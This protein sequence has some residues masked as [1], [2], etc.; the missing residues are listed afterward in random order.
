MKS[1]LPLF[2]ILSGLL[3]SAPPVILGDFISRSGNILFDANK[4]GNSE[5]TLNSIGLGVGASPSSNLH[6]S[7]NAY[8]SGRLGIGS[9]SPQSTLEIGGSLGFGTQSVSSNTT[10]SNNSVV[11]ADTSSANVE[12]TLPYAGNVAG[13]TYYIKKTT[14]TNS[15]WIGGGGNNIDKKQR[16]LLTS[17]GNGYPLLQVFS[18]GLQWYINSASPDTNVASSS[19][20]VGWW[21]LD[22]A[23][24]SATATDS[25]GNSYTGT[26]TNI[27]S[28]NIGVTGAIG[29]AYDFD[30]SNDYVWMADQDVFSPSVGPV[31]ISLWA[32]VPT[33][34]T[35][36]GSGGAGG[37]GAKYIGKG[38]AS[39]YEYEIE[40]DNNTT[41][42]FST[43]PL[44][45]S[46]VHLSVGKTMTVNDG[47]WHHYA[48]TIKK[49][50]K[51][52]GFIDGVS[53]GTHTSP[54]GSLGNGTAL[55]ILGARTD[56]NFARAK[57]DDVR[58][59]TRILTYEEIWALY[60]GGN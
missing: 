42:N 4:D 34:A 45:G 1:K 25:S 36:V 58:I 22:E 30:G 40:N 17:T 43:F 6:V 49:S 5:V 29:L 57:I 54:T 21:K 46:S 9:V 16:M 39:N 55:L 10:L 8:I 7:G 23:S 32:N 41:I 60:N 26:N 3:F 38:T 35:A 15:L 53:V 51:L 18:N 2:A 44:D 27:A 24:G 28:G 20:L 13:R 56:G 12:L 52:E 19:N 37:A 14:N 59:Y 33:N 50:E 47:A 11:I 48:M 31:T